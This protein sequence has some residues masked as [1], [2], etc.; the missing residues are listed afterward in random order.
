MNTH[1]WIAALG[2][3][4][5]V[6]DGCAG[7]SR[8]AKKVRE[9]LQTWLEGIEDRDIDRIISVY[10]EGFQQPGQTG[11]LDQLRRM[12]EWF[13][14]HP[15]HPLTYSLDNVTITFR[16]ALA[17]AEPVIATDLRET[18]E[19]RY[20]LR[21][22]SEGWRII[23]MEEIAEGPTELGLP[24]LGRSYVELLESWTS[25]NLEWIQ[26]TLRANPPNGGNRNLRQHALLMLD[27]P[28]HLRSASHL[29]ST[30]R[31]LRANTD[32][33]ISEM[34]SE[35]VEQGATI[36]K[37]YNHGWIVKTHNHCW[38]HDLYEGVKGASMRDDQVDEILD[39]VEVLFCSHWHG[40]HTSIPVVKSA[41]A[42]GI[43]VL[44]SPL[45][46]EEWGESMSQ[47]ISG[48]KDHSGTV[49]EVTL[50]EPGAKGEIR[51]IRYHA[52]PGHQGEFPN[53]AY[54]ISADGINIMQTGD[55][56]NGHDFEWIS[57]VGDD[58]SVDVLLPN[59]WT[60]DLSRII[61]GVRPRVVIPGHESEIGHLFEHREP[62]DQA[63]EKL[64]RE[65]VEWHVLAWGERFHIG[66]R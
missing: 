2:L 58:Y 10:S 17:Y 5:T 6:I 46:E 55:Q 54:L 18:R 34:R 4:P 23:K 32:H 25:A 3:T 59:V 41:L 37:M 66:P 43:P 53:N 9:V 35:T 63:F 7:E 61:E 47:T 36:W 49:R 24:G 20:V 28:L 13:F 42:K 21:R 11:G 26:K 62:Y 27:E 14:S 64:R 30:G 1:L 31:F 39:Q 38:A 29:E 8:D 57:R 19:I 22:E 51:G 60:T 16:D 40:D 15:D 65:E 48:T 33:A 52:Y 44:V 12:Y 50:V 45:P 56:S